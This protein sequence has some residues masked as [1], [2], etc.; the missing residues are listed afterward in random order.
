MP[1]VYH[2]TIRFQDTDSAG[3]VYFA[4]TLA[5]CHEAYEES[6]MASGIQV[7]KFFSDRAIALP[8]VRATVDYFRPAFCGDRHEIQVNPVLQSENKFEIHY[9]IR[10]AG[11]S[12]QLFSQALTHHVCI[13]PVS[14]QRQPL[15]QTVLDWLT[16][17]SQPDL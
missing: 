8:I 14:R 13:N 3:V 6:L 10:E 9:E 2:R 7:Q 16:Q 11:N 1:F 4:N 17:W 15:P 12:A 5:M